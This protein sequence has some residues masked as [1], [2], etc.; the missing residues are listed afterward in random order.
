MAILLNVPTVAYHIPHTTV[1]QYRYYTYSIT[2]YSYSLILY[3]VVV[4]VALFTHA[5]HQPASGAS[6]VKAS[7]LYCTLYAVSLYHGG[8]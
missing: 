4:L 1:P 8:V 3:S 5:R 6:R 2:T 7:T